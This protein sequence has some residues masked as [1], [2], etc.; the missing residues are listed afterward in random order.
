MSPSHDILNLTNAPR[1]DTPAGETYL[2]PSILFFTIGGD[3]GIEAESPNG[4]TNHPRPVVV[5]G[6]S[7][8]GKST[9]LTRLIAQHPG[10]FG[11][12]VSHTTRAPRQGERDGREYNF[13]SREDFLALVEQGGF[14]ENAEFSG[15]YYGTSVK[16]V[17]DV[18]D[19]GLICILDIEMEGVKQVKKTNLNARFTFI[20]PPSL[21]ILEQRL[22]GRGTEDEVSIRKRL[23]QAEKELAYAQ[24]EGAHEKI[25]VNDD[26]DTAHRE[27]EQF[28][29]GSTET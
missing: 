8:T 26:L 5:S 23:D 25:I 21:A 20:A 9:L 13:V 28:I 4:P 3:V 18:A 19:K 27:L 16:A 14:I 29:L 22:R 24:T 10:T 11:Y 12:S 7:G 6:P 15:N 1:H 2:H 17:R